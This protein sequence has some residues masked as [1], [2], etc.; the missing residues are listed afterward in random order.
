MF[1]RFSLFSL[2]PSA[3][4]LSIGIELFVV[5]ILTISVGAD[6]Y[7]L[8]YKILDLRQE[9]VFT[10]GQYLRPST[11][12]E[13]KLSAEPQYRSKTPVY[14]TATFGSDADSKY[15]IVLDESKGTGRGYD[16]LYVDRN[17][18]E[19]FTDDPKIVGNIR[20][21]GRDFTV[22]N[23]GPVEVMVDYGDRTVPYYFSV[24]HNLYSQQRMQLSGQDGRYIENMNVRLETSG[25]YTGVVQF[26]ESQH[27][28]AVIDFNG[29]GLFNEYFKPQSDMRNPEERLYA[30]GDQILIDLNG[31]GRFTGN[32]ELYPYAKYLQVNGN[33]YSLAI[34]AHGG[35]VE[36]QT[37][38]LK[39]GTIK[40][41]DG[42]GSCSFQLASSNG[43]L[44]FEGTGQEFQVPADTYQLYSHITQVKDSSVNWRYDAIG[45]ASGKQFQIAEGDIFTL[46]FGAPIRVNV[47]FYSRSGQYGEPKAG[48]TIEL[49]LTLSGQG[50]EAYTNI[51]KGQDRPPAPT[52]VVVDET[53]K[54]VAQGAFEYG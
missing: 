51:Q 44:N 36:V 33:W 6:E 30:I 28:I 54:N 9:G 15:T 48:D 45:T 19:K 2:T 35:K 34:P 12:S 10:M 11:Q 43:I 8:Q 21:Q 20:Q 40:I 24:E 46:H 13:E 14:V 37:P 42:M 16:V 18:D 22:G 50:G 41:P 27:Q 38:D 3:Y 26:G 32:K 29:N 47:S 7:E 4:G 1:R 5:F 39:F 25:Y 23:F 52:F 17:N 31:D 53:G 49:S